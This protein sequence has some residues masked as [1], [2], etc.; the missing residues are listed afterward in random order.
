VLAKVKGLFTL[1]DF[2]MNYSQPKYLPHRSA[3]IALVTAIVLVLVASTALF[4]TLLFF[5]YP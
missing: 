1:E 2:F 4:S 3:Q 5:S